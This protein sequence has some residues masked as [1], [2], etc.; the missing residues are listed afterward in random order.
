MLESVKLSVLLIPLV[1]D[2]EVLKRSVATSEED[3]I[4]DKDVEDR[5]EKR[6]GDHEDGIDVENEGVRDGRCEGHE[7]NKEVD[8]IEDG[9]SESVE[10]IGNGDWE[11]TGTKK[12]TGILEVGVG[13]DGKNGVWDVDDDAIKV[14]VEDSGII[15]DV[16]TSECIDEKGPLG[17][18]ENDSDDSGEGDAEDRDPFNEETNES[19]D[20]DDDDG[21]VETM[22]DP[23]VVTLDSTGES[24]VF[25]SLF[26]VFWRMSIGSK[27]SLQ[28]L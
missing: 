9:T 2:K 6:V 24:C 21:P 3:N 13:G 17:V 7:G 23:L 10:G 5:D 14:S 22:S 28:E 15:N 27:V 1:I 11:T 4:V 20:D 16:D 19:D 12:V 8:D 26:V 25:A 18:D